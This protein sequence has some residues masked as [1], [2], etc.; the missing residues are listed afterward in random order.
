[1]WLL[2]VPARMPLLVRLSAV[3]GPAGRLSHLKQRN[4]GEHMFRFVLTPTKDGCLGL[5]SRYAAD[6]RIARFV[7]EQLLALIAGLDQQPVR[8]RG[9]K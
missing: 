7:E 1:M 2:P 5:K 4:K 6:D 8:Q 3:K 9:N